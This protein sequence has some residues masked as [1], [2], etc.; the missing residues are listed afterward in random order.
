MDE[1]LYIYMKDKIRF[2]EESSKHELV[3]LDTKVHLIDRYLMPEIYSKPVY[4]LT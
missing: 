1:H 3:F 2:E 4:G